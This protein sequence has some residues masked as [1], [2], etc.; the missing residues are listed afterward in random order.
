MQQQQ[1][2]PCQGSEPLSLMFEPNET[3][4][5]NKKRIELMAYLPLL[6][7]LQKEALS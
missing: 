2:Q 6:A 3:Y 1:Q 4:E 5:C 7:I